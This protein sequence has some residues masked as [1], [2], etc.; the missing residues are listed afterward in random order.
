M[1][2]P[3]DVQLWGSLE[4]SESESE[5]EPEDQEEKQDDTG[6]LLKCAALA[7]ICISVIFILKISLSIHASPGS[8]PTPPRR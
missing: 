8:A 4:S 6:V 7:G 1:E 5:S 2:E 3:T